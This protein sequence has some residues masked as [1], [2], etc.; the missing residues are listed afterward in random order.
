MFVVKK[1]N[2]LFSSPHTPNKAMAVNPYPIA[3]AAAIIRASRRVSK[4]F[5]NVDLV[6]VIFE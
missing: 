3:Q 1:H 6:Q 4:N 5:S 2:I